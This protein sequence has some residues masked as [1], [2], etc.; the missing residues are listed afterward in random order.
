MKR[1][2]KY[3]LCLLVTIPPNLID[4]FLRKPAKKF[5]CDVAM[6]RINVKFIEKG[7]V[8]VIGRLFQNLKYKLQILF[9]FSITEA[10]TSSRVC[11][12][13]STAFI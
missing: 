1:K 6:Y 12:T 2:T 4:G 9:I 13:I 10:D 5:L 3:V 8:T 7:N 11:V